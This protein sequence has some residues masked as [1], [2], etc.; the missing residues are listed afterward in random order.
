MY[1][2][3]A[4]R[5]FGFTLVDLLVAI[6]ILTIVMAAVAAL[7]WGSVKAVRTGTANIEGNE[8]QRALLRTVERDLSTAFS[9]RDFGEYY[10]FYGTPIGFC[11][12]GLARSYEY[13][14]ATKPNLARV[15]Y[16]L[17]RT[18]GSRNFSTT[19]GT[20]T[21]TYALI[22]Y[23]EPNQRDLDTFPINWEN[24][25]GSIEFPGIDSEFTAIESLAAEGWEASVI[26]DLI[27]A[28]KRQLWLRMLSGGGG[29]L[30][31]GWDLIGKD[32]RDY[33]L[34][35]NIRLSAEPGLSANDKT[36]AGPV[37]FEY[38]IT[39]GASIGFRPFW[40]ADANM[41]GAQPF[42][43]GATT[44]SVENPL[45]Q[46]AGPEPLARLI[47]T[48]LHSRFPE[49]VRV[50]AELLYKSPYP[51]APDI[52]RAFEQTMDVPSAYMR[53]EPPGT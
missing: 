8:E 26:E 43:A 51:G 2:A 7:M 44:Q 4:S 37:F 35:E 53:T 5:R 14:F 33:V 28:K 52:A 12:V 6:S 49:V 11:Y 13:R 47:G 20:S 42:V 40:N 1:R 31:S 10:Q 24:L 46:A 19:Y 48:P 9:G 15:T 18:T 32:P 21:S 22:R 30:P 34:V 25:R 29:N 39:D 50:R 23:I 27:R 3:N 38:G 16:V 45:Y 17:H 41:P 36:F